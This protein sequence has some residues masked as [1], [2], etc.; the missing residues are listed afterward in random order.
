MYFLSS[1]TSE[2][3]WRSAWLISCRV[4]ETMLCFA[5]LGGLGENWD[6][7]RTL[8]RRLSAVNALVVERPKPGSDEIQPEAIISRTTENLRHNAEAMLPLVLVM[9]GHQDKI[10]ELQALVDELTI[11]YT[12]VGKVATKQMLSDQAWSLRYLYGVMKHLLY[13]KQ[14]PRDP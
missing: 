10:P 8:V 11:A 13:R 14:P 1:W 2:I 7:S 9:K 4:F 12:K 3:C 6:K 5:A